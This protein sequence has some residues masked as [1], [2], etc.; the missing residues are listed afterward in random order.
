MPIKDQPVELSTDTAWHG[1]FARVTQLALPAPENN[2]VIRPRRGVATQFKAGNP[3]RPKGAKNHS[4]RVREA[5]LACVGRQA[6]RRFKQRLNKSSNPKEYEKALDQVITLLGPSRPLVE[7]DNSKHTHF[8][9]V[10]DGQPAA[11]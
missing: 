10:L 5:L 2:D 3:G 7:V 9:V 11:S 6:L 4:T 8:T 1:L